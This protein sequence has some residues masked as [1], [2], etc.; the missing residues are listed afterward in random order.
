MSETERLLTIFFVPGAWHTPWVFDSV[1]SILSARGFETDAAALATAGSSDPDIGL[2]DDAAKVRS[3]LTKL[4][5]DG[6]EVLV[7]AHSY[8]GIVA[9][10]AVK[11]LSTTQRTADGLKGGISM[12]VYLAAFTIPA[13][14]SLVMAAGHSSF[15]G[16]QGPP[17]W[18]IISEVRVSLSLMTVA[19][20]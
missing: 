15:G 14:T 17:D 12:V 10:N 7:L 6:K 11:G 20:D 3:A 9:S 16:D 4:I 8:G 2:H 18:W 13:N 5:D 1:R 19:G